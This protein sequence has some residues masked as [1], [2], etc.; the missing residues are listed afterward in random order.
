MRVLVDEKGRV[1]LPA[2]ERRLA[3]I[4]PGCEVDVFASGESGRLNLL[5]IPPRCCV[6][7]AQGSLLAEFGDDPRRNICPPCADTIVSK[8][9]VFDAP[10]KG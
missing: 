3:R 9:L 7:G 1:Q 6:C 2:E 10:K 8:T 4:E 5:A